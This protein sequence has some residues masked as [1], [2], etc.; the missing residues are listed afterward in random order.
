[1]PQPKCR[2]LCIDDHTDTSEMLS[3]ILS[4]EDYEVVTAR[5]VDETLRLAQDGE[6]DMYVLDKHLPDG[7]G[8][9]LCAKLNKITPGVPCLVYSGDAYAIH[10]SEALAAGAHAYVVKPDIEGLIETANRLLSEKQC[11]AAS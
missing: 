5:T 6:F 7:S 11:A 9:D 1:M 4:H 2:I 8:L 10:K 3:L